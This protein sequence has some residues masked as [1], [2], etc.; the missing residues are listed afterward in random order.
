[1]L[2]YHGNNK[3]I[4]SEI[5]Q[6]L[7]NEHISVWFDK[8]RDVEHNMYTRYEFGNMFFLSYCNFTALFS[9]LADGVEKAAIVCC[10]LT[11]DYEKSQICQLELQYAHKLRKPIIPCIL[12]DEQLWKNSSW[13]KPIIENLECID[14]HDTS[15]SNIQLKA[16]ELI[17]RIKQPPSVSK[18]AESQPMDRPTY[19]FE[20]IKYNYISNSR[21]ERFINP[22]ISYPI[23][24]AYIN[25][26]IVETK[27]QQD[28]E[29]KLRDTQNIDAV[30]H[31]FEEIY[32]SK[33]P[34]D[35]KDIFKTCKDQT[36]Q[37]LV[38]GRAGIGKSTFCRYVAY[39][40]AT[41]VIWSEYQLVVLVPLRSLTEQ[42][43][44][45]GTDYSLI[46][47]LKKQCF[48][49]LPLS[50]KEEKLLEQQI[51]NTSRILWILDGYDE[52]VQ[53]RSSHLKILLEKL[54]ETQHHIITSRP[55]MNNLSYSVQMEI[56]GFTNENIPNYIKQFFD[57]LRNESQN[58]LVED[59]RLL[60]F[61][62]LNPRI[63][64]IAHIPINLEIICSVW[65]DTD[66]SETTTMTMT[67]LYDKLTEWLCR[68]YLE[69]QKE[70]TIK[71]INAISRRD[72][73]KSCNT[74]LAFL[75]TLAFR[76]MESNVI[77]LRPKLLEEAEDESRCSLI[78]H[79]HLLN[80]G[81]LKSLT[82]R[83]TGT[84][85]EPGKDHHF[86]HLSF[87][88]YFA[89]RYL[90]NALGSP[91]PDKA[92]HFIQK[93]KYNQRFRLVFN[94]VSGLLIESDAEQ[95]INEFWNTI[96][97][98]PLDLV[99]IQHMDLL[100]TCLEQAGCS[101]TFTHRDRLMKS[102]IDWIERALQIGPDIFRYY[103]K[104]T[105][106]LCIT[107][108][109]NS[110][111]QTVLIKLLKTEQATNTT[112]VL[113]FIPYLQLTT[114][115]R[116]LI[117]TIMLQIKHTDS[118]ARKSALEALGAMGEKAATSEVING[119]VS[120]L[121]DKDRGVR[122]SGCKALGAMGEKAATSE[123]I[124]ELAR[125]LG[126]ENASVRN[127][128]YIALRKMGE[129]AA[130]GE[131]I[132][133]LVSALGD[134]DTYVRI[135]ACEALGEMGE[136][137][138]T[139]KLIKVLLS[140]LQRFSVESTVDIEYSMQGVLSLLSATTA[141]RDKEFPSAATVDP[142]KSYSQLRSVAS[143]R[144][145]KAYI[146]T[147]DPRWLPAVVW[148]FRFKGSAVTVFENTIWVYDREEIVKIP[149]TNQELLDK[150]KKAFAEV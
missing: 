117:D 114:P 142:G 129:K 5:H 116:E 3:D 147:A 119:L 65:S 46:D 4:I 10:F 40:W 52:I 139:G 20:L 44:Q 79:P 21:I 27:Y 71:N 33:I 19:L 148:A 144:L 126:D 146:D 14:I 94:F 26:A 105:L 17:H 102:I 108:S 49:N 67:I 66:W 76:A 12:S 90:A 73:Y 81:I 36:R 125:A 107:I 83:G 141:C 51:H 78:D 101:R 1:M 85:I 133:Q 55:Y 11:S 111:V 64:G 121:G 22:S 92:I 97:S 8:G 59:K 18:Y 75:E 106:P 89:A 109:N 31:T 62:K 88:E 61:L 35:V 38:F 143:Q 82:N 150:M 63:S 124:D 103:L 34:I 48:F 95:T 132:N 68:Q 47:V 74:E 69:K 25:L 16:I 110:K 57:Q 30:M 29:K 80:I 23:E 120:T 118:N 86:V 43:Y 112:E 84:R 93:Q 7:Q 53:T 32:G 98:E 42:N 138:A 72:V 70:G 123:V 115:S 145:L 37:V 137:A 100:I 41:G 58:S 131:V 60:N 134:E 13:L 149:L 77:V 96:L 54:L 6:T 130:T 45:A 113:S 99:G 128:A 87:Q 91:T 104:Q 50:D 136:K 56:T 15:E 28:K 140:A 127:S 122:S 9:S 2:S 24:Q 39:Q 135:R